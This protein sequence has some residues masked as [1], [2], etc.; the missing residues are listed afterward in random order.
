[1]SLIPLSHSPSLDIITF[2]LHD[3]E[4]V[5]RF[6]GLKGPELK[7]LLDHTGFEESAPLMALMTREQLMELA[8]EDLWNDAGAGLP[9]ELD[10]NRLHLWFE[11]LSELGPAD[12]ARRLVSMDDEFVILALSKIVHVFDLESLTVGMEYDHDPDS[13]ALIE[14][15]MESCF[16]L[17][18]DRWLLLFGG[19][20]GWESAMEILVHL[21]S[22]DPYYCEELLER[23]AWVSQEQREESGGLHELLTNAEMLEQDVGQTREEARAEAG[24]ISPSQARSFLKYCE[25]TPLEVLLS[26]EDDPVSRSYFRDLRPSPRG[27]QSIAHLNAIFQRAGLGRHGRAQRA[28]PM[29]DESG[30]L[31]GVF[32]ELREQNPEIHTVRVAELSFLA[33]TLMAGESREGLPY[34]QQE[35]VGE[36]LRLVSAGMTHVSEHIRTSERPRELALLTEYSLLSL[37]K[38][39]RHLDQAPATP[40]P[41]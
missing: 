39:G 9:E 20:Y 10:L 11:V 22:F 40:P 19:G 2:I 4:L 8:H 30:S 12:A 26:E 1:M 13:R 28:L 6:G 34:R 41:A 31:R 33:N 14:K 37:F 32:Q 38:V 16:A 3:Q 35:A 21:A 17:E 18:L 15:A 25:V 27:E 24:Y 7:Q 36:A 29:A 5:E 23:L